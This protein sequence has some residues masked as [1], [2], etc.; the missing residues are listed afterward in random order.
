[1]D[2]KPWLTSYDEGVPK[3]LEYPEK[4]LPELLRDIVGRFPQNP[5]IHFFGSRMDYAELD[6]LVDRFANLLIKEGVQ[7]GDR[8]ALYL[9]NCPPCVIAFF[10][11]LR[12][13]A[14]LTQL[15]PLYSAS[16]T[17]H[18]LKDSGAKWVVSLDRFVPILRQVANECGLKKVWVTRVN[19]YFPFPLKWLYPLKAKKEKTWV[20][21]P[22][23]PLFASFVKELGKA[24]ETPVRVS[25]N[26]DDTALLQ[27]TGGTTGVAKGVILT[28]RNLVAN[29]YQCRAWLPKLED[30]QEVFMVAIPIFHCYGMTVGMNWAVITGASMVLVPKFET[31][32]VLKLIDRYQPSLFPGVQAIYVAINNHPDTPKYKVHSIKACISGAGPLHVEVQKKFEE[33]TG[34]K[35]VE[36]Y[37]LTEASPV[38]HCNPVYGK[39][40]LGMIGLPFVGTTAKIVDLETG[41]DVAKPGDIGELAI[42]GPQVMQGYWNHPEETAM[43]LKNGWLYTGDI[44]Y[45][46]AEGFFAIVDRKKDMIKVGGENVY[47][48]DVEE[49]L[50]KNPKVLDC[51]VAGIPDEKLVDKVKAYIVLKPGE[52]A[53]PEEIIG[54]CKEQMAKFKVPK[55]VEFRD[56]LPKNMVGKMLRRLLVEEEKAKL[57]K[58]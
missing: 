16:E 56:A 49:V 43:V 26:M 37:G 17:A 32:Q 20:D 58:S 12:A 13:G 35:L 57:K 25:M 7:P 40:K 47:P 2:Q 18:Q 1:M 28:H 34:G 3:T 50:F 6:R 54:F 38:T 52:K 42:Q 8:V 21:W 11:A 41:E 23:E 22:T 53:T 14:I 29:A 36:G 10:G 19:D 55:E 24:S 51:V 46:D 30:G 45:M 33:L 4:P 48:R 15:N 39:R 31:L 44:G 9:P 5:A 27:Y